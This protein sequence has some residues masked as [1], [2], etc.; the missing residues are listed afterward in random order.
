MPPFVDRFQLQQAVSSQAVPA[1]EAIAANDNLRSLRRFERDEPPPYASSTESEELDDVDIF[2]PP[3]GGPMPEELKAIME[4]PLTDD[5]LDDIVLRLEPFVYP[6]KFYYSEATREQRRL[7]SYHRGPRPLMFQRLNGQRRQGVIVRHLVKRRW[8]KLGVWNPDWGFAGRKLQPSDDA[9][10]WKWPWQQHERPDDAHWREDPAA[11]ELVER[12][13]RLRQTL[14]HGE[15][16]PVLPRSRPGPDT[17]AAQAEA[18]LIS[19]PWFIFQVE[20]AEESERY[21]RLSFQ[22]RQ[23]YPRSVQRHVIERWKERGDWR[24]KFRTNW[25]T[26]WKWRHESPSPEPEDLTP[27]DNMR[28]SPLDA[29]ED[30]GFTPS[31]I[32]ELETI[33]LPRSEQPEG[34]WVIEDGD[35]PPY[36]PGQM[37]DVAARIDKRQKE[38]AERREKARAEGHE[39]PVDPDV[40]LFLEKFARGEVPSL[41]GRASGQPIRLPNQ[42]QAVQD[43]GL[44]RA[45]H[46]ASIQLQ[47]DESEIEHDTAD[48]TPQKPRRMRQGQL[49]HGADGARGHDQPVVSPPRRSAR[50]AG[51]KRAAEPQLSHAPPNKR[52]RGRA[53]RKAAPLAAAPAAQPASQRAVGAQDQGQALL[54]SPRRSTRI[55]GIK[56][57]AEP[58]LSETP[59]SKRPR[60]RPARKAAASVDQPTSRETPRTRTRQVPNQPLPNEK[61][62]ARQRRGPG[63]PRK[64][65]GPNRRSAVEGQSVKAPAPSGSGSSRTVKR[66][67]PAVPKRRGRPRKDK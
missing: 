35:E 29:A 37:Q 45:E 1:L 3:Q 12:A 49:R 52:P 31:E 59:P 65:D 66:D 38:E 19:R 56:R 16:A 25:V 48:P 7:D 34:F 62:E 15:H 55:A 36:F 67:M 11:R 42:P 4:R 13:L 28:D 8:Q 18:F 27:L 24:E 40:K 50:L 63:R 23:R 14:R 5:E 44:S 43:A 53:P 17:T 10:R 47:E 22:D 6:D 41:F 9:R 61:T 64:M 21:N 58:Q 26:G 32:D 57:A 46:E 51:I 30:M 33:D 54:P 60:G 39:I 20:V 2:P